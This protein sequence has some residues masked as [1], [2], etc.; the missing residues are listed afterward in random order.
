MK[1]NVT[2]AFAERKTSLTTL[3]ASRQRANH[4]HGEKGKKEGERT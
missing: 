3:G 4:T 2:G 1:K